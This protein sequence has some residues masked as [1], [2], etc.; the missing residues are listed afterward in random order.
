MSWQPKHLTR[1]QMAERRREGY[2]LLQAGWRPA[3]VARELGVS[4]AA[5]TQW[6]R[7]F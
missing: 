4:R 1:E 2:R 3:A 5:V 7:R 6:Q